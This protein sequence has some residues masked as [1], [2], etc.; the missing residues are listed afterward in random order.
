MDAS[1]FIDGP[2]ERFINRSGFVSAPRLIGLVVSDTGPGISPENFQRL[3]TEQFTTKLPDQGTGLGLSIVKRLVQA[4][5]GAI[6]VK[7]ELGKGTTF[8]VFLPAA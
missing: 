4:V 2:N 1:R 3:F 7:S 6:H 5:N 8:T